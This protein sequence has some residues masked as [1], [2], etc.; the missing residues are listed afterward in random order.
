[1]LEIIMVGDNKVLA[2]NYNGTLATEFPLIADRGKDIGLIESSPVLA[3][4]NGDDL[5]DIIFGTKDR[6][7]MAFDGKGKKVEGFPLSCGAEVNSSG[8]ILD[9]DQDQNLELLAVA[10]DGFVYAWDLSSTSNSN[11]VVWSMYG[12]DN[13]HTNS[14]PL[15]ELPSSPAIGELMPRN[16]VYNYPNPAKDETYIR[17]F[18]SQDADVEIKIYDLA[19]DLVFRT[20]QSGFGQT[21]N[22]YHWDCSKYASGV[23][24]CRVEAKTINQKVAAF[25]KIALV[26]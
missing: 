10:L 15:S 13:Q 21:D 19:G 6:E 11:K 8:I 7:I 14:F 24:V 1:Y 12:Y 9:L 26:K 2:Y 18:L 23:Y 16:L 25:C 4:V 17:Y 3:D 5:V 20:V 22:E